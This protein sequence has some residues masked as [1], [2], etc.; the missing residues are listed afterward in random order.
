VSEIIDSKTQDAKA[1]AVKARDDL[2]A[3]L[4][5]IEDKLNVPK[6]VGELADTARASYSKN[7]VPWIIGGAAAAAVVIGL[8]AWA[9]FSD[10]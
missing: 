2:A 6:R 1:Q 7:P 10:D 4:D 9:I 3:T 8:V 5:A